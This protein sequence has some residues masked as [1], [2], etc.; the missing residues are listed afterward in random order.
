MAVKYKLIPL[1]EHFPIDISLPHWG[2]QARAWLNECLSTHD[3]FCGATILPLHQLPTRVIAV[4]DSDHN[5]FLQ[6]TKEE[7]GQWICLSYVWGHTQNCV[8]NTSNYASRRTRI[9]LEDLST[10]IRDA[11]LLTRSIGI[12]YLWV[13][14]ICIIQDS[15]SDWEIESGR[16]LTTVVRIDT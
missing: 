2:R 15:K 12:A 16:M 14:A 8:T 5:P 13:D 9:P 3:T 4:G 7:N 11:I 10:T 1:K 6:E